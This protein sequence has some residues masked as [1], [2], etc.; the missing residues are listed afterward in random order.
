MRPSAM[1]GSARHPQGRHEGATAAPPLGR[2]WRAR[3]P[4]LDDSTR[5][6]DRSPFAFDTFRAAVLALMEISIRPAMCRS[7]P[8]ITRSPM[9]ISEKTERRKQQAG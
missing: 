5:L 2:C 3:L 4:D 8:P 7:D 9:C 1:F 6:A